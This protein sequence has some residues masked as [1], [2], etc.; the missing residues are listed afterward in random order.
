MGIKVPWSY[1]RIRSIKEF[2]RDM[3][4]E[5]TR[6]PHAVYEGSDIE[7]DEEV[8][9]KYNKGKNLLIFNLNRELH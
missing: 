1:V 7:P 5:I 6:L 8:A 3:Q 2:P 9:K 4:Q